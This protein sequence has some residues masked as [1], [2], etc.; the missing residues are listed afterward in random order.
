MTFPTLLK[1][2]KGN[3]VEGR[4]EHIAIN[5]KGTFLAGGVSS[6]VERLPSGA[7]V[8]SPW[9]GLRE[10]QCRRDLTI[11]AAVYNKL[12]PHPRLVK[13]INWDPDSCVLTLEY[14]PNGNLSAYLS[15]H[16][17][18]LSLP[19]RLRWIQEAAEGLQLLHLAEVMHC[20]V[21]P[22]N[23]L[24]D[25]SLGLRITDF[26]GSSLG[27]SRATACPGTRFEPPNFDWN[28]PQTMKDDLFSLG[29]TMYYILTGAPPYQEVSSEEVRR[30]YQ[31]HEFP[32]VSKLS[33]G[34]MIERCWRGEIRSAQEIVD[35]MSK[36]IQHS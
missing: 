27:G 36:I 9:P 30:R 22:K 1:D 26:G 35:Y 16:N 25:A 29:S 21:E 14:M 19:Q 20:D 12:P 10:A 31:A 2:T 13:L 8:K 11:E 6:I 32:D 34:E 15:A 33:C 4:V 28:S 5:W 24:L 17:Y 18:T 23:F 7:V 3:R